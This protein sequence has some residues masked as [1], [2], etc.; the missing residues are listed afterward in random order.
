MS[1]PGG[2]VVSVFFYGSFMDEGVRSGQGWNQRQSVVACVRGFELRIDPLSRLV[3]NETATV[4]GV[5]CA[6]TPDELRH[7]YSAKL[8]DRYHP[9]TVTAELRDGTVLEVRVYNA[10]GPVAGATAPPGYVPLLLDIARRLEFPEWYQRRIEA[11][12]STAS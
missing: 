10:D 4:Y 12:R 3:R 11:G 5:V 2:A 1:D 6:A 7:L 9:E 8:M